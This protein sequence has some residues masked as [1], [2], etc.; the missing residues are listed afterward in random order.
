MKKITREGGC[1]CGTVRYL[2]EGEPLMVAICHCT[3]CRRANAAPVVAW[4]MFSK[5]QVEFSGSLPTKYAASSEVAR[6]FCGR[7]GTQLT[8]EATY[9]PGLMDIT[10]GSLDDPESVTPTMHYW[11]SE[12]LSWVEFSDDLARHPEFPPLA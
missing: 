8:F 12:H 4:A 11:H 2:V 7:C 5:D 3:T 9:L 6:G 10:V 1:Q